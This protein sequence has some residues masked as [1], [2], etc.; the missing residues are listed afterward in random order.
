MIELSHGTAA[1]LFPGSEIPIVKKKSA[2]SCT[3]RLVPAAVPFI[4]S[5]KEFLQVVNPVLQ[6]SHLSEAASLPTLD[7]IYILVQQ[8]EPAVPG[9]SLEA[10]SHQLL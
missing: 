10:N 6:C 2:V 5:K 4:R 8:E 9:P 1:C 7:T 3:N